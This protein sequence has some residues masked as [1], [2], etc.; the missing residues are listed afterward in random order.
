MD[1][2]SSKP[3]KVREDKGVDIDD[4]REMNEECASA[5]VAEED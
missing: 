2:G 4:D 3:R 1:D 5:S